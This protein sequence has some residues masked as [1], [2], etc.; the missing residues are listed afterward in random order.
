MSNVKMTVNSFFSNPV[1]GDVEYYS[2]ENGDRKVEKQVEMT[3]EQREGFLNYLLNN[4]L[5]EDGRFHM[6]FLCDGTLS[7]IWEKYYILEQAYCTDIKHEISYISPEEAKKITGHGWNTMRCDVNA[8]PPMVNYNGKEY[9][10][11]DLSIIFK[12]KDENGK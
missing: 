11:R 7:F 9:A 8:E 4:C 3:Q 10:I 12:E 2:V 6:R 1:S 5:E